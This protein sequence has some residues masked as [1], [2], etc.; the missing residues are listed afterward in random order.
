[1]EMTRDESDKAVL[2][3]LESVRHGMKVFIIPAGDVLNNELIETIGYD[4]YIA[5]IKILKKI[6]KAYWISTI[7]ERLLVK[8]ES[9]KNE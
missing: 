9:D 4:K 7:N 6:D 5:V 1:M 8:K 2:K 3:E